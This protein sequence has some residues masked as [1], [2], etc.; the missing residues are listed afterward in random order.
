[1][2]TKGKILLAEDDLN[3]GILLVDYLESEGFEVK[4]CR[5]GEIALKAFQNAVYEICLLDIMMPKMDGYALAK[6]IRTINP[7]IPIIFLTAKSL[8]EDKVKGIDIGA[9]DYIT[10]PF[11]EEELLCRIKA[12][13]RRVGDSGQHNES[14]LI[15]IGKYIFDP[16]NQALKIGE[17]TKRITEKESEILFYLC[18]NKNGLVKRE[19]LLIAVWGVNDYFLGR[20]L[21][22][23]ITKIR[24]YLK[25]DPQLKIENIHGVGFVFNVKE[26]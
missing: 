2:E 4:L 18:N 23:F 6:Q 11:E 14:S 1:M 7:K 17:E 13:I 8:K 21:D 15:N 9:D 26:D 16:K 3:F 5:D 10:K 22:V 12:I 24:K 20:S 19:E 25:D